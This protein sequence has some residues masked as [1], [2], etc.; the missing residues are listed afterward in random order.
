MTL[1]YSFKDKT[2]NYKKAMAEED[3]DGK[4]RIKG[5]CVMQDS[6]AK[7]YVFGRHCWES[8]RRSSKSW[9]SP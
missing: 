2:D 5:T 1:R 7:V 3:V 4:V 8:V 9:A 6:V